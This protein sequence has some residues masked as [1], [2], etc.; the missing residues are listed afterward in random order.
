MKNEFTISLIGHTFRCRCRFAETRERLKARMPA[1]AGYAIGPAVE[2]AEEAS[3]DV[4]E[5]CQA[6]WEAFE[7]YG[8]DHS[9]ASEASFLTACFGDALLPLDCAIIHAVAMRWR[10]RAYL[11]CANSGTGK[12]TQAMNLKTLRPGE[13]GIICGDRPILQ[14]CH[15]EQSAKKPQKP[16]LPSRQISAA[17]DSA[18]QIIVHPSP[19]NGKENWHDA[20]SAVLAGIILLERGEKNELTALPEHEAVLP[21]YSH[22]IH[23]G[24]EPE[25]IR[26]VAGL[27]TRLLR[28]VPL[29]RLCSH[30]VPASTRLLLESVF[31]QGG[32][33]ERR[34]GSAEP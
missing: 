18:G 25:T 4:I 8:L 19:W 28:S 31:P 14:F 11:I 10:G 1:A 34:N 3:S 9:P 7:E 17:G 26:R 33:A 16:S 23:T 13:F 20:D 21:M 5:V 2:Q 15:S 22:M 12:S 30:D 29:W 27:E 32:A 6:D 24:W